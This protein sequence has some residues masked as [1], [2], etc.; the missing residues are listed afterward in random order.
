MRDKLPPGSGRELEFKRLLADDDCN[1]ILLGV[2]F[3]ICLFVCCFCLSRKA[4]HTTR[5]IPTTKKKPKKKFLESAPPPSDDVEWALLER[6]FAKFILVESEHLA[7]EEEHA[8][9]PLEAA[10][11]AGDV[12]MVKGSKGSRAA[13][14]AEA[15]AAWSGEGKAG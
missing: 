9:G 14:I 8:V 13:A 6:T 1:K 2:S 10:L 12:V 4:T 3:V 5:N 15:L 11:S 7:E